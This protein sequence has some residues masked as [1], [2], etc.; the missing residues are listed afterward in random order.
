MRWLKKCNAWRKRDAFWDQK[1]KRRQA[2][3]YDAMFKNNA[4]LK[5]G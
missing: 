3:T 5:N 4:Q 2:D 1:T